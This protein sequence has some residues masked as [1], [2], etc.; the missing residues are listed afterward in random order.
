MRLRHRFAVLGVAALTAVGSAT[1]CAPTA[2][3]HPRQP[4]DAGATPRTRAVLDWL[5]HL[6]DRGLTHRTASGFFAGYSGADT[7]ESGKDF[8][9]Q[10]R[11]VAELA[12]RTGQFPAV[13]ACDYASGWTPAPNPAPTRIDTGCNQ[14]LIDHARAGGLVSVSVHLPNPVAGAPWRGPL[15]A[16]DFR[17]LTDPA[18]P[19]GQAWRAEL[20][21]IA[22]GLQTLAD[23]GVPVLFR[24]FH[25]MNG[26]W[27]WW[28][29][30]APADFTAL[31]RS[32][33]DHLTGTRGLHNLLWVYAPD[34][35]RGDPTDH[36]V[37]KAYADVVGLDCYSNSPSTIGTAGYERLLG[38]GKPFAFTEIGPGSGSG[39][40]F[41]YATW[42]AALHDRFPRTSY[43]LAWNGEWSPARN[44]NGAALMNDPWTV[45]RGSVDTTAVAADAPAAVFQDF[46]SGTQGWTGYHQL[47]GPWKV[48]EWASHGTSSLKADIDL[49]AGSAFLNRVGPLDL[50]A[51]TTL[52]LTARTA[53]WGN[54]AG[55]TR[56]KLYIRT[57]TGADSST[58]T[59]TDAGAKPVDAKGTRFTLDLS[60]VPD[61]AHVRE[62]GVE[63]AP[64]AGASGRTAVYLDDVRAG[65]LLAGFETGTDGF[66][67]TGGTGGPWSTAGEGAADGTHAL[68]AETDLAAG[69]VT[70]ARTAP[71]DLT[72][73][74]ALTAAVGAPAGSTAR[75]YLRTGGSAD[76]S[77]WTRSEG[78]ATPVDPD[79][80]ILPLDLTGAA[81]LAHVREIGVVITPPPGG[82]G[83]GTVRLD[84]LTRHR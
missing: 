30:Q 21:R 54:H 38:L 84:A 8:A 62:I 61:R 47:A 37:G 11:Q 20:D 53:L 52:S 56:A 45:N 76:P 40:T 22:D 17:S 46:E 39:G 81:D 57:G 19:A 9:A 48:T 28:G 43:F 16:Q 35:G 10:Y 49:A 26:D 27:F 42:A 7:P 73:A 80:R 6:P 70:L 34:C 66:A 23:A 44:L 55:G 18:T 25:E 15:P 33:Y 75:L 77:G 31:W 2:G 60:K 24:P 12:D 65:G 50:G 3:A 69:P 13:L 14:A 63:F 51:E 41:D 58:W 67:R 4:A 82:T 83:P 29:G 64:A 79:G 5:G 1:A 68:K 78:P 71:A 74:A 59:W 36:Y 72:G 32:T